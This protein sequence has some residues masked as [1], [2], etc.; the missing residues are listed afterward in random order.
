MPTYDFHCEACGTFELW[1]DHR[2]VG[3]ATPCP[4][5]GRAARRVFSAPAVRSPGNM[6]LMGGVGPEGRDRIERA[7]T[8]EPKIAS[9]PPPGVP[10]GRILHSRPHGH[11]HAHG[12]GGRPGPEVSRLGKGA[13]LVGGRPWQ[14]GH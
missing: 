10:S 11:R 5:C 9:A 4:G 6:L 7:H 12:A 2:E 1:Q 3:P 8:G 14:V 13:R